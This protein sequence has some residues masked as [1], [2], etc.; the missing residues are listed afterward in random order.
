MNASSFSL[1]PNASKAKIHHG[2][3]A[4]VSRVSCANPFFN[5][6]AERKEPLNIG[7]TGFERAMFP[8]SIMIGRFFVGAQSDSENG[9]AVRYHLLGVAHAFFPKHFPRARALRFREEEGARYGAIY[10]D[11]VEDGTGC[12]V[13]KEAYF[14]ERQDIQDG[15]GKYGK[16]EY[17]DVPLRQVK[18]DFDKEEN[19]RCPQIGEVKKSL[20]D[21]G[22]LMM[23]PEANYHVSEGS[24]VFFE[25]Y[26]LDFETAMRYAGKLEGARK[27]KAMLHIGLLCLVALSESVSRLKEE[28]KLKEEWLPLAVLVE[29]NDSAFLRAFLKLAAAPDFVKIAGD[30]DGSYVRSIAE[31]LAF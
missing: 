10:S 4:A 23:H 16:V 29:G 22:M 15:M 11:F 7:K 13:R 28:G 30:S 26:H 14:K 1:P 12:I 3:E 31:R 24:P 2:T 6:L 5:G 19:L 18:A 25:P 21:A 27:G 9:Q 17:I 20:K 8:Q